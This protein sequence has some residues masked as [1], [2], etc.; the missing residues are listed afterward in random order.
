[1][2]AAAIAAVAARAGVHGGDELKACRELHLPRRARDRHAPGLERLA[3][4]LEHVA[5]ELRQ[6]VEEKYSVMRERN[7]ARSRQIAAADHGGRRRAVVRRAERTLAPA[8]GFKA[9]RRDGMN[10]RDL[11]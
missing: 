1:A 7:F 3:Q 11:E 10:R 9:A 4:R 5:V 2:A 6:L 8:G